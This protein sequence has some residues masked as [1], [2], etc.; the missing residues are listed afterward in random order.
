M[1]GGGTC[2]TGRGGEGREGEETVEGLGEVGA[3]R[4]RRVRGRQ[5]LLVLRVEAASSRGGE[6]L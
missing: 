2:D 4:V 3:L 6:R 1:G 5:R